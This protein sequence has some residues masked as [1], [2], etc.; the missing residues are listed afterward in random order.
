MGDV[1]NL[2]GESSTG[3]GVQFRKGVRG[4]MGARRRRADTSPSGSDD[5]N[6]DKPA[7]NFP[8][9]KQRKMNPNIQSTNNP[10]K[11]KR[12]DVHANS[13][14]D[15]T[16]AVRV[17]YKS[18]GS[19]LSHGDQNATATYEFDTERDHDAQAIFERAMAVNEEL[20]GQADDK[21]YRGI[22]NYAMYYK[23]KDT[24]AGNASSGLVRKGPIRAPA[25]LRATV[26]W[27]Y[28][29]DICKDYKETGFCGFGDSCK[30]LHDRGDYKHGWQLER[31]E[32][33]PANNSDDD[34][35]YE[36]H[37]DE[38]H[39][40]FKCFICRKSFKDPIVTKCKH[41]FCENC[42]LSNYKKSAR[43]Y[44]CNTQTMGVFN[45]AKELINRINLENKSE[46]SCDDDSD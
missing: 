19:E 31:Q 6:K 40:P 23:K 26:R 29:P 39:L 18:K 36:V 43:C 38:E 30:F 13:S 32:T 34:G 20:E 2:E 11:S 10:N 24:A 25:N 4:K 37:S 22:N 3:G 9:K 42:A 5:S 45:P 14:D 1:A 46:S 33:A 44:I 15:E 16:S 12:N 27:D 7:V 21:V 41:Y 28:Q 8:V 35:R 17:S